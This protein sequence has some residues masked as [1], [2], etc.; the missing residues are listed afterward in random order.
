MKAFLILIILLCF[1]WLGQAADV[2]IQFEPRAYLFSQVRDKIEHDTPYDIELPYVDE[3]RQ[4]RFMPE[5]LTLTECLN[6]II[7]YFEEE[8][9]L[10]LN[11]SL[12]EHRVIF[13]KASSLSE[14]DQKTILDKKLKL[15][16]KSWTL[17]DALKAASDQSGMM[18]KLPFQD[19][20]SIRADYNYEC[21][22]GEFIEEVKSYWVHEMNY[23][24]HA[25]IETKEISF[26]KGGEIPK[27][28]PKQNIMIQNL[29]QAS[30]DSQP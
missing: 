20:K 26:Y 15:I 18:I 17:K 30:K 21:T 2:M 23:R 6:W 3:A 11:F 1:T 16:G 25:I 27:R 4:K 10:T 29:K 19:E 5:S 8:N 14:N 28:N 9:H 7:A 24:I 13:Q 12:Q 22:L